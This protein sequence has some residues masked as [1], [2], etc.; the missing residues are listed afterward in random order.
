MADGLRSLRDVAAALDLDRV[1]LFRLGRAFHL[2]PGDPC[3]PSVVVAEAYQEPDRDERYRLILGWLL[4]QGERTH[5]AR[6]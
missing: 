2:A 5:P 1:C 6:V 4:A 3:I